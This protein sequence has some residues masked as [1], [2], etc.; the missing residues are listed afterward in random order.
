MALNLLSTYFQ[1]PSKFQYQY[2]TD[3]SIMHKANL[4]WIGA[5]SMNK[6]HTALHEADTK[7]MGNHS[8]WWSTILVSS[9][10]QWKSFDG[11]A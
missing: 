5:L 1:P 4:S 6:K 8:V 9:E 2:A 7:A 10:A 11:Y 3:L